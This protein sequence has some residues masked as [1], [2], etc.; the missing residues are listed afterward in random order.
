MDQSKDSHLSQGGTSR[1]EPA[2]APL[3]QHHR[4]ATGQG[5]TGESNPNGAES[6]STERKVAGQ[7]VTY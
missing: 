6:A 7:R 5:V 1:S 4:L 2:Q 3:R